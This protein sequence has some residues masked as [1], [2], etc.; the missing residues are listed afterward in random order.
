M[1]RSKALRFQKPP[2]PPCFHSPCTREWDNIYK[3]HYSHIIQFTSSINVA[4]PSAITNPDLRL[5][6]GL[7]ASS[8]LSLNFVV[9]AFI[10]QDKHTAFTHGKTYYKR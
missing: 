7:D 3:L 9:K 1:F 2:P 4:A 10:L 6:N 8:G 5:S